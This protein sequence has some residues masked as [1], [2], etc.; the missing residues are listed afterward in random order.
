VKPASEGERLEQELYNPG[1]DFFRRR[2]S[3]WKEGVLRWVRDN[4]LSVLTVAGLIVY[5]SVRLSAGRFYDRFGFRPE[6]V[7]LG[8]PELIT[9]AV[10]ALLFWSFLNAVIY[11][12]FSIASRIVR[13]AWRL[14]RKKTQPSEPTTAPSA[15][16]LEWLSSFASISLVVGAFFVAITIGSAGSSAESVR[17]GVPAPPN[18]WSGS[19]DAQAAIVRQ[20]GGSDVDLIGRCVIYFGQADG[21]AAFYDPATGS[22]WRVPIGSVAIQTGGALAGV[23]L[24][25]D[26]CPRA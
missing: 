16:P 6:E 25:P 18:V 26:D 8:Y 23:T 1:G 12:G 10:F 2:E 5:G 3:K 15:R 19:W 13:L 17:G 4:L 11:V 22:S 7:G 14:A 20:G 24:V 21:L 9:R